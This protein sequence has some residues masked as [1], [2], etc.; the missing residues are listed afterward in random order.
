M[1][2]LPWGRMIRPQGALVNGRPDACSARH[3][4]HLYDDSHRGRCPHGEYWGVHG[5]GVA[6]PVDSD[7]VIT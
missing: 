1:V 7:I 4:R 6:K 5:A 3:A 2:L